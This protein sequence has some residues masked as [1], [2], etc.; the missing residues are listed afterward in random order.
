MRASSVYIVHYTH[1]LLD[2]FHIPDT[3][4][5]TSLADSN[6]IFSNDEDI[7]PNQ[8]SYNCIT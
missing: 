1:I 8:K 7:I 3:F 6:F 2:T 4:Q 5:V